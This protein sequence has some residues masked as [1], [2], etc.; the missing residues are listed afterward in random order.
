MNSR[1]LSVAK[2]ISLSLFLLVTACGLRPYDYVAPPVKTYSAQWELSVTPTVFSELTPSFTALPLVSKTSPVPSQELIVTATAVLASTPPASSL[3]S[4]EAQEGTAQVL[5]NNRTD[6]D[7]YISLSGPS[8]IAYAI[9]PA[10]SI[11]VEIPAGFY[12]YW[13]VLPKRETI[14][15]VKT[16]APGYSTWRFYN[17]PTVLD[18]PTPRWPTPTP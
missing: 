3:S 18:S 8:E 2:V 7:L 4:G 13:I 14:H 15:G 6:T 17:T 12:D 10:G 5:L 11:S 9:A 1:Y 16:F